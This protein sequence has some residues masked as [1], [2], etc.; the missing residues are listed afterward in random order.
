MKYYRLKLRPD[1]VLKE[2]AK[3]GYTIYGLAVKAGISPTHMY[4]LLAGRR[5]ASPQTAYRIAKT[6]GVSTDR[7]FEVREYPF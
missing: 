4:N 2:T 3:R 1:Q 7:I 6:L 5:Y